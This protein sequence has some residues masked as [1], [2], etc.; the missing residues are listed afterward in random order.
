VLLSVYHI[1]QL[2]I[3]YLGR[4]IINN[5]GKVRSQY[6]SALREADRG[7]YKP[8]LGFVRA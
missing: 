4:G 8:L 7:Y 2:F 1:I 3:E 6:I 5:V